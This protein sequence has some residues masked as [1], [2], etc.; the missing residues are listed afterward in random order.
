MGRD[1]DNQTAS[2][3]QDTE[4]QRDKEPEPIQ[5]RRRLYDAE[6]STV[7]YTSRHK[8]VHRHIDE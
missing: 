7:T 5:K 2:D 3:R 8:D 4:K 6:K 1:I